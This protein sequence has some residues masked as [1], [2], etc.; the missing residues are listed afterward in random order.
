M[1]HYDSLRKIRTHT[2]SLHSSCAGAIRFPAMLFPHF[3]IGCVL[4]VTMARIYRPL[5]RLSMELF[6]SDRLRLPGFTFC[7]ANHPR[8]Q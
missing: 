5:V 8:P 1:H 4:P 3:D 2:H 7:D 6:V